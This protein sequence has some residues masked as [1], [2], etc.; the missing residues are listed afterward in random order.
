MSDDARSCPGCA[1]REDADPGRSTPGADRREALTLLAAAG[2][3]AVLP[4]AEAGAQDAAAAKAAPKAGDVFVFA[5]GP[6]KGETVKPADLQAEGALVQAWP[7]DDASGTVKSGNRLNR[8]MLLR[9]DPAGMDEKTKER[10]VDG[11]VLAYSDFCTHAGCF[12]EL[13]KP[14]EKVIYCHCHFS[15]FDPRAGAKVVSGPARKPLA[16]LPVKVEGDKLT[17]AGE[18]VGQL[19]I[20]KS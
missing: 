8:V 13:Y 5:D 20:A 11:G 2:L 18:F 7:K 10:A 9:L 4:A 14:D 16:S 19:G 15:K 12:I 6:K 1:D 3:A 17:V